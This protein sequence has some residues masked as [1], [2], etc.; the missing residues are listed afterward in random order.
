MLDVPIVPKKRVL[1]MFDEI[2]VRYEDWD[3]ATLAT[4]VPGI[5]P[6]RFWPPKRLEDEAFWADPDGQLGAFYNP[7]G[8]FVDDPQLA[9]V[10]LAA[11]AR[12][13][14]VTFRFRSHVTG[15]RQ[16]HGRVSGLD[17]ADGTVLAAPVVVNVAG[18][19]SSGLNR[20]A[21]RRG[22]LHDLGAA[23]A[24]GGTPGPGPARL[25]RR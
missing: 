1:D 6:G 2:G 14:G 5:D 18:P 12:R 25:Q 8:G 20:V 11:A 13:R 22:R 21:G 10:N 19:W 17:L 3:A 4:R 24:P 23:D 16:A 7:D 15:V 9:A